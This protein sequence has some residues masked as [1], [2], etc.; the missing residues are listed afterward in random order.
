MRLECD[1]AGAALLDLEQALAFSTPPSSAT[2]STVVSLTAPPPLP[3]CRHSSLDRVST[4]PGPPTPSEPKLEDIF[5]QLV[6]RRAASSLG[7]HELRRRRPSR[8]GGV[9]GVARSAQPARWPCYAGVAADVAWLWRQSRRK[10]L[11][12]A[13]TIGERSR[14]AVN[15]WSG[16]LPPTSSRIA[17][18]S[19]EL[20]R[21]S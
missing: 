9:A 16:S 3:V 2:P 5:V 19:R 18:K 17:A 8:Q 20:T 14:S 12:C 7:R 10:R 21:R 15:W 1:P 6:R 11:A 13:S 4:Y